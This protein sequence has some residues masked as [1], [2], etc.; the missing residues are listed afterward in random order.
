MGCWVV[1]SM[2]RPLIDPLSWTP[3]AFGFTHAASANE[4]AA[5][6]SLALEASAVLISR[7]HFRRRT[8]APLAK[9]EKVMSPYGPV[10]I[11]LAVAVLAA[12]LFCFVP[13]LLARRKPNPAKEEA[14]E[15]G[16]E[17]TSDVSGRF[18]VR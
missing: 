6:S 9:V 11:F 18:P 8:V 3:M 10:A 12:S 17:P 14:Y 4:A 7:A 5:A 2:T 15:C 13:G 16:V 1:A